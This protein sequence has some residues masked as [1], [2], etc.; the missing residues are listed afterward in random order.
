MHS[1]KFTWATRYTLT[2][3]ATLAWLTPGVAMTPETRA[4]LS[5][6]VA[7]APPLP[8]V[9]AGV[10]KIPVDEGGS[11]RFT[12]M[13]TAEGLSQTRVAQIVQDDLGFMWF[14]TQYGLNR[15]DGYEF[16]LYVHEAGRTNS[17]AG[18]FIYSLIRDRAGMLWIGCNRILDRFD[19]RTETFTH[20]HIETGDLE[21]L[22]GTVVHISQDRSGVLWL[23]TGTGLHRLDPT[24]GTIVHYRHSM[25]NPGGLSTNDITWSGEDRNGD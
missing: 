6:A 25:D 3:A 9:A 4:G 20:Y 23:A 2:L 7:S 8:R 15:Y 24:T 22:G 13:S 5:P 16:K 11:A 1:E 14:G 21:N 12:R 17:L 19:P 18:A 10:V